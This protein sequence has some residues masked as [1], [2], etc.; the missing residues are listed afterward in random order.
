ML[1]GLLVCILA[2]MVNASAENGTSRAERTRQVPRYPDFYIVGAP[3]CGTTFMYEYLG[4]HPDIYVSPTKEPQF[5][6]TDL[7]SGSYLDSVSFMRDRDRYLALFEAARPDQITGEASTWYLYSKEAAANI[8]AA[9]PDALIIIML[10]D[11]VQM[12]YSLHGRRLYG[13]SENLLRFE[14]ALE[15]EEARKRGERIPRR[16]RNIKAL[17]YREVGRYSEQV[18]RY[19][20]VFG[21]RRVRIILFEEFRADPAATYRGTLE[22]LGVDAAFRPDFRVVNEGVE[23]RSRRVQQALLAPGVI[24]AARFVLPIRA[25]PY[26][27]RAWDAVNTRGKRRDPLDPAVAA[28]LREELYPD[29]VRLGTLI[30]RDVTSLWT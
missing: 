17:Y 15:A 19:L 13:G 1:F 4:R 12:L 9:N 30:G 29:M 25:R 2:T 21:E 7:D 8:K 23:R 11:P 22:F 28:R 5:F 16:A 6:A 20:D 3:R 10:R 18:E 14:D 26:V 27:G 24:R